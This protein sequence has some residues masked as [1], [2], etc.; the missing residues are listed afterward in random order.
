MIPMPMQSDTLQGCKSFY[1]DHQRQYTILSKKKYSQGNYPRFGSNVYRPSTFLY[2]YILWT[3]HASYTSVTLTFL[4]I[5]VIVNL[6]SGGLLYVAGSA[7]P[8]CITA[9]GEY[10]GAHPQ[11]KFSDAFALSWMTLTTVGYGMTYTS[12]SN[13]LGDP[14]PKNAP[15][16]C[17]CAHWRLSWGYCLPECVL[18]FCMER[19][20]SLNLMRISC[21]AIQFD[22]ESKN[23]ESK[24]VDQYNGCPI[25]KFQVVNE[26]ANQEGGELVD[27]FMKAV[28]V[29]FKGRDGNVTEHQYVRVNLVDYELRTP[30]SQSNLAWRAHIGCI[31]SSIDRRG[32]GTDQ[33]EQWLVA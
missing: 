8:Y 19:S 24:F 12:T 9:S 17:F 26:L 25:L 11:T 4:L 22:E 28:G 5:Y 7:E 31:V 21:L 3:F 2:H 10:F 14:Y 32:T 16:L 30:I 6:V 15:G 33:R 1:G 18:L 23:E 27:C 20:I 29:K 13:N